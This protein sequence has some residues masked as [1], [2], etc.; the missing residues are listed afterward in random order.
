MQKAKVV[1]EK[2][3]TTDMESILQGWRENQ[4]SNVKLFIDTAGRL[5]LIQ[6]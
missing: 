4:A 1:E 6:M 2:N 3:H 5:I